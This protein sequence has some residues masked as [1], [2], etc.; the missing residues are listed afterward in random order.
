MKKLRTPE[1]IFCSEIQ[2]AARSQY[3][4]CIAAIKTA[5]REALESAAE[6]AIMKVHDGFFKKDSQS[7]HVQIGL[8]NIQIDKSSI[9]DLM[10]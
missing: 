7:S 6:N 4:S 3:D 5:Q 9:L 10:P 2:K 1:E 8:N